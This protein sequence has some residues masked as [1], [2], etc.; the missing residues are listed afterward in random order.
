M[1]SESSAGSSSLRELPV[2][3]L[4]VGVDLLVVEAG[5]RGSDAVA[6]SHLEVL[7]E[8]L[9]A[10]PPV[11]PDHVQAL[12][13]ADLVEVR[14]AN[15]VLLAVNREA[16]IAVRCAMSLVCLTEAVAPGCN[17]IFFLGLDDHVQQEGLIQV[18]NEAAPD[19]SYTVRLDQGADLPEDVSEWILSR[20]SDV[21]ECTPFLSLVSW[22]L[23]VINELSKVAISLLCKSS[24][25]KL[26]A[27]NL[28]CRS[29]QLSH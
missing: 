19:K 18:P 14:V 29:Y 16:A 5:E 25:N 20:A 24:L 26:I 23:H 3:L 7:S 21:L 2:L 12:V 13:A 11:G 9:V 22:L 15:I 6:L 27:E 17:H 4:D 10:A 1:R 28:T 8:V